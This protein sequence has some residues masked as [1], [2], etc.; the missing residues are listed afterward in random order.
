MVPLIES[1]I[2]EVGQKSICADFWLETE[3]DD[4]GHY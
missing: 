3:E 4:E 1:Q 2:I